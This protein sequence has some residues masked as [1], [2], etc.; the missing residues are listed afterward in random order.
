M[1]KGIYQHKPLSMEARLKLKGRV[2]WNKGKKG[3]QIAWNKGIKIDRQKFPTMGHFLKHSEETKQKISEVKKENP[4]RYWLG[5]KTSKEHK[6]KLSK[7]HFGKNI[8]NQNGF[9][10]GQTPWNKNRKKFIPSEKHWNW[11]GGITPENHKIRTSLEM[12]L[13]RK[14]NMERDC[15]SCLKCKQIGGSLQVHHINNFADFLELRTS[16][17]NGVTFCK[18]CHKEFHKKYGKKNNTREQLQDFLN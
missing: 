2:A 15:F 8:G 10:K 18:N 12:K 11:K 3:V 17:E 5:K 9:K 14:T 16:I 4:T 7:A 13:W 6:E 1:P